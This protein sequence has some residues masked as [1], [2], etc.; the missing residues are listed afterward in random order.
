[1]P[2]RLRIAKSVQ[3]DIDRLP[4]NIRQ[5]IRR[6]IAGLVHNPRP[7]LAKAMEEELAGYYRLRVDNYRINYT[8]DDDVVLVEVIRVARRTPNAYDDL[9]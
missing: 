3:R 9:S 1:M 2:Y 6:G 8:I 4:G 5:R 7:A